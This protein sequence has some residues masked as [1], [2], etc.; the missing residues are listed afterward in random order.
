VVPKESKNFLTLILKPTQKPQRKEDHLQK[1]L[2]KPK[3]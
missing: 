3:S 1:V 2:T